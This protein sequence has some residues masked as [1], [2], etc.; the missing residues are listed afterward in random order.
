MFP[1]IVAAQS[2]EIPKA[3]ID[4]LANDMARLQKAVLDAQAKQAATEAQANTNLPGE[5]RVT[6]KEKVTV[7]APTFLYKGAGNKAGTIVKVSEGENFPVVDRTSDWYAVELKEPVNGLNVG[8]IPAT[9]VVLTLKRS[10]V[11][12]TPA[13]NGIF[14][15]LAAEAAQLKRKYENNPYFKVTGFTFNTTPPGLSINFEFKA[16]QK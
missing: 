16:E 9:A 11:Q 6:E 8:W 12:T 15:T 14:N 2:G 1:L 5:F 3:A 4:E 13:D 7:T 10:N